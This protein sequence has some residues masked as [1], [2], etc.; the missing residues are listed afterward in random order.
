MLDVAKIIR[1]SPR[2]GFD[3]VVF[4]DRD[5]EVV[6][7]TRERIP[8]A[9]GIPGNF[10][11]LILNYA[12]PGRK[13]K[14]DQLTA[15]KN[16]RDTRNVR[17]EQVRSSERETLV[18]SFPFDVINLDLQDYFFR[19]SEPPPGRLIQALRS[20]FEWQHNQ[21]DVNG[22]P[23][24]LDGFTL[25]F[26]TR[27]GPPQLHDSEA[28]DYLRE[29]LDRNIANDPDLRDVIENRTGVRLISRLERSDFETFFKIGMPKA[30]LALLVEQEWAIEVERGLKLFEFNRGSG[31]KSYTMLHLVMDVHEMRRPRRKAFP[32]Q[33]TAQESDAYRS[34]ARAI[35]AE[36]PEMVEG[37]TID[38]AALEK[39]LAA[40]EARA[41]LR[42]RGDFEND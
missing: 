15:K 34:A 27:V 38:R 3:S 21:F 4:V 19:T 18:Q 26:T 12:Q 28:G 35:C 29:I 20:V 6:R 37:G 14:I 23:E 16:E 8:G 24:T 17:L 9:R 30:L 40:I 10:V 11:D 32:G 22:R 41:S 42:A 2:R 5:P 36:R 33:R 31:G 7:K 25:L 13:R 1:P 39:S